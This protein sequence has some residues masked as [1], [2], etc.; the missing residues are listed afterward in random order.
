[1]F[2]LASRTAALRFVTK[3]GPL[4]PRTLLSRLREQTSHAKRPAPGPTLAG[5]GANSATV[6]KCGD[7][8]RASLG[9]IRA[10]AVKKYAGEEL[11]LIF[12]WLRRRSSKTAGAA[13]HPRSASAHPLGVALEPLGARGRSSRSGLTGQAASRTQPSRPGTAGQAARRLAAPFSFFSLLP[14]AGSRTKLFSCLQS[15]VG[16]RQRTH[17]V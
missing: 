9:V 17:W 13:R 2:T 1:M 10:L 8:P 11:T 7:S 3:S 16:A 4:V 5:T 6:I 14:A 12:V 15:S